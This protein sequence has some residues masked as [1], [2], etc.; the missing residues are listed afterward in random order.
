VAEV[1]FWY[2]DEKCHMQALRSQANAE[3]KFWAV[4]LRVNVKHRIWLDTRLV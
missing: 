3:E 1:V 4:T 2:G